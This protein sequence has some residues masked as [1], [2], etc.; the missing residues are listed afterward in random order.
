[1]GYRFQFFGTLFVYMLL[2]I[3]KGLIVGIGY[4]N[5][6]NDVLVIFAEWLSYFMFINSQGAVFI[7]LFH[8]KSMFLSVPELLSK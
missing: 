5:L 1:M 2:S 4:F 7:Y 6:K 3:R 8:L